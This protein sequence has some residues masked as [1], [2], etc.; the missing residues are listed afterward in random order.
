MQKVE[1]LV[2]VVAVGSERGKKG[3]LTFL[4]LEKGVGLV[5]SKPIIVNPLSKIIQLSQDK[6][7]GM[8]KKTNVFFGM[9]IIPAISSTRGSRNS[10]LRW[11]WWDHITSGRPRF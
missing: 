9:Y 11:G 2:V 10:L 6:Y 5:R 7:S 8:K 3:S 1:E 4:K